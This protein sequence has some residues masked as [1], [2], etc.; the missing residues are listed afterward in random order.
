LTVNF[1]NNFSLKIA[2]FFSND[3]KIIGKFVSD[4]IGVVYE[5]GGLFFMMI[6]CEIIDRLIIFLSIVQSSNLKCI[7]YWKE[8]LGDFAV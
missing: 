5:A 1:K 8:L 2:I 6:F 4:K 7:F 3:K